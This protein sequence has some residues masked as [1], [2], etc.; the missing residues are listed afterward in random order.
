M[1]QSAKLRSDLDV[2]AQKNIAHDARAEVIA[3]PKQDQR[4][5]DADKT[6]VPGTAPLAL[7]HWPARSAMTSGPRSKSW[8]LVLQV[9]Q[10]QWLEPLM[11]WTAGNDPARQVSL[12][13]TTKEAALDFAERQ[14]WR[15]IV[16]PENR[17]KPVIKSYADNFRPDR[18]I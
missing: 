10:P 16:L 7:I 4:G 9:T 11:G 3:F 8:R 15:V 12:T 17:R 6:T 13:F 5:K 1:A 18:R 14:G 2:R